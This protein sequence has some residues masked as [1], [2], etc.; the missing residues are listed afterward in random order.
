MYKKHKGKS[1]RYNTS[2]GIT[3]YLKE[4]YEKKVKLFDID[5]ESHF[6][7]NKKEYEDKGL[8]PNEAKVYSADKYFSYKKNIKRFIDFLNKE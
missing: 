8:L 7:I 3:L 6:H 4:K 2:Y 5:L 1:K